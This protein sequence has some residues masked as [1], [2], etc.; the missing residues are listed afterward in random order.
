MRNVVVTG[1]SGIAN[2]SIKFTGA[3]AVTGLGFK[4]RGREIIPLYGRFDQTTGAPSGMRFGR[5]FIWPIKDGGLG[6]TQAYVPAPIIDAAISAIGEIGGSAAGS[7]S[8]N[9]DETEG[10]IIY[11][12]AAG[13]ATVTVTV[14]GPGRIA[15][16]V[17]IGFQPSA[18]DIAFTLLDNFEIESGLTV[19]QALRLIAA[20]TAGKISGAGG[21]TIT[22]RNAVADTDDRVTATVDGNGNRTA[23]TYDLN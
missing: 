22:I 11:G 6:A 5:S 14:A 2:V 4:A 9:A 17:V 13:V 8:I 16:S 15:A 18:E 23:I 21:T 7:V 1:I 19:R 20:V 10:Q 12:S 3:G